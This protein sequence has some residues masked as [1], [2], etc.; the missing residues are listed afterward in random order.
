MTSSRSLKLHVYIY[1]LFQH[2]L[3][4]RLVCVVDRTNVIRHRKEKKKKGGNGGGV[5]SEAIGKQLF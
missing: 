4:Y 5:S 2:V 1:T 3:V